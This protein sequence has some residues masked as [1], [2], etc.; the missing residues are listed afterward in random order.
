MVWRSSRAATDSATGN[1]NQAALL[2]PVTAQS[3]VAPSSSSDA[4]VN[5]LELYRKH[6]IDPSCHDI[7]ELHIQLPSI[8]PD[9]AVPLVSSATE[10]PPVSSSTCPVTLGVSVSVRPMLPRTKSQ[11][12]TVPHEYLDN[13]VFVRT[14]IE[15]GPAH[16]DGRLQV[17]D[18]LLSIDDEP[19]SAIS[20]LDALGRLKS[21][22][23]RD[24][25]EKRSHVR[26]LISR[27]RLCVEADTSQS[28]GSR[29]AHSKSSA[30]SS[31]RSNTTAKPVPLSEYGSEPPPVPVKTSMTVAA[32][33]HVTGGACASPQS[34]LFEPSR[35]L[36]TTTRMSSKMSSGSGHNRAH[37]LH[38]T[39]TTATASLPTQKH[40]STNSQRSSR[41]S[42]RDGHHKSKKQVGVNFVPLN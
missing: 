6:L 31:T 38:T 35:S 18:R 36:S 5:D 13:A 14:L 37:S 30:N 21:V 15:G 16:R 17:G 40:S 28:T 20:S 3:Q 33:V 26:L 32:E 12:T 23:A 22:I 25:S 1:H 41:P 8:A 27:S 10:V 34:T 9:L 19:L 7:F 11:T 4:R 2:A 29:A 39:S 42:R 24:L